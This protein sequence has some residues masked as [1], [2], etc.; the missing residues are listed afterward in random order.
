MQGDPRIINLSL[1]ALRLDR[2]DTPALKTCEQRNI[3][4]HTSC[5][6]YTVSPSLQGASST[7]NPAKGAINDECCRDVFLRAP[8]FERR[9]LNEPLPPIVL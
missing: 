3:A 5:V 9:L 4:I 1:K 7:T 8:A 6:Q 2:G